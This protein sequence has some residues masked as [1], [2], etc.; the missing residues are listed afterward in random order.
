[1]KGSGFRNSTAHSET[2]FN[3]WQ[4]RGCITNAQKETNMNSLILSS[5]VTADRMER[6]MHV[7]ESN[8]VHSIGKGTYVVRS[9]SGGAHYIVNSTTGCTCPDSMSR[10]MIC[11]HI[12]A[13]Y[14]GAVPTV[15][16]IQLAT[17][18]NEAE[19][20]AASFNGDVP[21][22]IKRTVR[23]ECDLVIAA[24]AC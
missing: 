21:V 1:M 20:I 22:G 14:V 3:A 15:W 10:R 8:L 4:G 18:R 17:S 2:A 12:W 16:R 13:C 19:Q 24:L 9:E 7:Y 6:G 11:K 5:R 23:L